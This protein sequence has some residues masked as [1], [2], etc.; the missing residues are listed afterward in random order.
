[1]NFDSKNLDCMVQ[2]IF[3]GELKTMETPQNWAFFLTFKSRLRFRR[4]P[5]ALET[6]LIASI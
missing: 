2:H 4:E 6:A 3:E 1:M 5:K